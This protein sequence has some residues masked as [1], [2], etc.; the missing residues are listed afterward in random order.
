M[1]LDENKFQNFENVKRDLREE[2]FD[3]VVIN[4]I[5]LEHAS[6]HKAEFFESNF[7]NV[8]SFFTDY[9]YAKFIA[10][11]FED[12]KFIRDRFWNAE[13]QN[14]EFRNCLVM[15]SNMREAIFEDC[16]FTKMKMS[17]VDMREAVIYKSNIENSE[18]LSCFF[19][20]SGVNDSILNDVNFEYSYDWTKM[21][22]RGNRGQKIK[23]P[24]TGYFANTSKDF[25]EKI[26]EIGW[27][28]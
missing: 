7:K 3:N 16:S 18:F 1:N 15:D 22:F 21:D 9:S 8:K 27:Y 14:C 12:C 10:C 2:D 19:E 23:Y 24:E 11:S 20:K 5:E 13:F 17:H 28:I 25:W 6:F 26:R 4:S